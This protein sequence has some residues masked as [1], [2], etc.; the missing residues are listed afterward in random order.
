MRR[1]LMGLAVAALMA[2]L[3]AVMAAPA[4]AMDFD[5]KDHDFKKD[6]RDFDKKDHRDFDKKDHDDDFFF[7]KDHDDDFNR[8]HDF[9]DFD[10]D[11]ENELESGPVEQ[12]FRVVNFGDYANQCVP[13]IQFGNTGNFNNAPSFA[14]FGSGGFVD[15]RHHGFNDGFFNDGFFHHGGF[16]GDFEPGGIDFAFDPSLAV[17]CSNLIQ[18]SSAASS[19]WDG[20][21]DGYSAW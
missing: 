11:N 3:M 2:A 19:Y 6:H 8:F 14:Q 12:D 16:G 7:F 21:W 1:L 17:D 20:Y 15:G 10:F 13:A 5:K 4:L 9:D 18:Q